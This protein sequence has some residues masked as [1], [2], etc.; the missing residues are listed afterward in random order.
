MSVFHAP[1]PQR[2]AAACAALDWPVDQTATL[3][4]DPDGHALDFHAAY[5]IA[6]F[7]SR[8]AGAANDADRGHA[9]ALLS[10]F[11]L[12][13]VPD[14]LPRYPG[15]PLVNVTSDPDPDIED[16]RELLG[17]LIAYAR[18]LVARGLNGEQI[19]QVLISEYI[20]D[21][22]ARTAATVAMSDPR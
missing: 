22:M 4:A 21:D 10:E 6:W 8:H 5:E 14:R 15:D 1:L 20:E 7:A 16:P 11:G 12:P 2:L 9:A 3:L 13:V 17:K 19:S 18:S